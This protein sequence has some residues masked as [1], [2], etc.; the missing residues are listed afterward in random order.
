M[1]EVPLVSRKLVDGL[2]VLVNLHAKNW[3]T[4]RITPAPAEFTR[5]HSGRLGGGSERP[6]GSETLE[7]T[8]RDALDGLKDLIGGPV[9][10]GQELVPSTLVFLMRPKE[11]VEHVLQN[12]RGGVCRSVL[13]KLGAQL[14]ELVPPRPRRAS[15]RRF[16]DRHVPQLQQVG[17][18]AVNLFLMPGNCDEM[19]VQPP[20][21]D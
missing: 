8:L 21:M 7:A 5:P 13:M 15:P 20:D 2:N 18:R 4:P 9:S 14:I 16:A 12:A 10:N 1:R 3:Y 17:L 6:A 19:E 11:T